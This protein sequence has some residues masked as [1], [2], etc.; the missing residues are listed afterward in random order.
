MKRFILSTILNVIPLVAMENNQL[1]NKGLLGETFIKAS[2]GTTSFGDKETADLINSNINYGISGQIKINNNLNF[3]G[4]VGMLNADIDYNGITGDISTTSLSL[5]G[6]YHFLPNDTIDPFVSL[7]LAYIASNT[8][9]KYQGQTFS[10]SDSDNGYS[11]SA[12]A[13]FDLTNKIF[14]T[15]LLSYT[16]VGSNDASKD[17]SVKIDFEVQKNIYLGS[18]INID[19]DK[20]DTNY[21]VNISFKF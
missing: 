13:E 20:T 4:S 6:L 18:G 7:S 5:G 12:G 1:S 21:Y 19:I 2:I 14:L 11:I 10:K 3:G 8:N 15:P 9:T 17:I 16:K